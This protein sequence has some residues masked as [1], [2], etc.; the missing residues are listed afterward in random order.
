[1]IGKNLLHNVAIDRVLVAVADGKA[2]SNSDILDM[3]GYEGVCFIAKV[4][5]VV[6]GSVVTLACQS[7]DDAA[8]GDAATLAGTVTATGAGTAADDDLLVLDVFKP[9]ERYVRAVFTTATQD[10]E[11]AG[12]IAIR[13]GA[14]KVPITQG[15][16]VLDSDVLVSPAEA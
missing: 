13:Y 4:S 3:S 11:K 10:A 6:A 7:G 12:V 5:D 15:A 16:T 14:R 1:M 2:A 8:L 9:R